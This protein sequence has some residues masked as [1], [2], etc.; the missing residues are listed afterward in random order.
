MDKYIQAAYEAYRQDVKENYLSYEQF[1]AK[2][3]KPTTPWWLLVA[4]GAAV[5]YSL[6]K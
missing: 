3:C 5:G 6:K 2:L 1:K 4:G